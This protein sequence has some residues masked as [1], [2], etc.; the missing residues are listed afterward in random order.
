M[1]QK[2]SGWKAISVEKKKE[3]YA[4]SEG[5]KTYLDKGK[6]ERLACR[7]A[8]SMAKAHG[9]VNLE[10]KENLQAGDKVYIV[11]RDKNLLLAVIGQE[12]IREGI[13]FVISH[14]DCP[15]IDLKQ[16]PVYGDS[17]LSLFKT[18]YYGGI[19]KYQW[20]AIPLALHGVVIKSDGRKIDISLG[21]EHGDPVLCITDLL[22]H[23]A[24]E[25]MQKKATEIITGEGL[26][27][28]AGSLPDAESEKDAEKEALLKLLQEKYDITE[29]DFLS[30]ELEAVPA[31]KATDVGFDRS[32]V[33]A[34]GHDDRVCVYTSLMALF[35][36]K[37]PAKTAVCLL[38]DKEEIGSMGSTGMRS[39]F[40]EYAI[41]L[42]IEKTVGSYNE[43]MLK[44]TFR[45]SKCLSSDVSAGVDPNFPE[46]HD[47]LNAPFV[48]RGVV[49]TKY[50]G[51][52]GK[53]GTSDASAE[54]MGFVRRCFD[55][56]N[57]FWQAGELGKVDLGGGGTI[58]Q[59]VANLDME[60]VD[61]GVPLLSM[62]APFEVASKLDIFMAY[63]GYVAFYAQR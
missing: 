57:V 21:D 10:E 29:E 17:G 31:F 3:I 24:T 18:H 54:F 45:N 19:K 55:E 48:G 33:G 30:A 61:C 23:L 41:A 44:R 5:Y 46:V 43:L 28:L 15:R 59:Y 22:P 50:T 62:H 40:F 26:N 32:M 11:N 6:T 39:A 49:L 20:T 8:L 56:G 63:Q 9:F 42:L 52:R 47:K 51:S 1:F 36:T 16:N 35:E 37:N 12:D 34:Y 53:S 27:I 14:V 25:Q 13:S 2:E 38:T 4:F 58:A 60:V 7:E